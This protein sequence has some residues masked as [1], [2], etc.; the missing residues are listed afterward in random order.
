ME[1]T[2][3]QQSENCLKVVLFG[4]ESTGKTTLAMAL[5]T[6]YRT[7]WVPEY[8]RTYLQKKWDESKLI[9][10]IED[11]LPIATGQML[12]ENILSDLANEVLFCDT[13]LL[14]VKVYSEYYF[15]GLCPPEIEMAALLNNYD[16]YF[17]TYIDTPW[18]ED[19]LRDRQYDRSTL[20]RM[21][22]KE[23]VKLNLPHKIL[24]GNNN[25]RLQAAIEVVDSLLLD[26]N[27]NK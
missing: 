15:D 23:L 26:K 3:E 18:E 9:C 12:S 20:F 6:H 11:L 24:K 5:A 4:P 8:M 19:D 14:E 22:E 1:K 7:K 16:L 10:T 21:F 2:L 13:N 25:T 17:L 27:A